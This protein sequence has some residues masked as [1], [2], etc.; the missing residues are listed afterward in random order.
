MEDVHYLYKITNLVNGKT[1][2]G[3]TNN[4][5]R[6]KYQHFCNLAEGRLVNIAVNKYGKENFTFNVL[7]VGSRD[8]IYSLESRAIVAYNSDATNGHGYNLCNGGIVNN[9]LNKGKKIGT[10]SDDVPVFV[11]GWWFPNRRKALET[12]NWGAGMYAFRKKRNLLGSV[13]VIYPKR[14]YQ[15]PVYIQDF[16]FPDRKTCLEKL[17]I[18]LHFYEKFR[19][20]TQTKEVL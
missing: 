7:C 10:R 14:K 12:L 18:T 17:N 11:S 4:P 20:Q 15:E 1:Y 16:W 6:R 5:E 2:I 13:S 8:Y 9:Q 3:V 19:K